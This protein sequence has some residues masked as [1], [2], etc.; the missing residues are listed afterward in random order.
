MV[1]T[2]E[3]R[4]SLIAFLITLAIALVAIFALP[5]QKGPEDFDEEY[6]KL[7]SEGE[8]EERMEA[9]PVNMY[10]DV[11]LSKIAQGYYSRPR[12]TTVGTVLKV[13]KQTDG[14]YH[15]ILTDGKY[16]IVCEIIP[17]MVPVLA[18]PADIKRPKKGMQIKIGGIVRKDDQHGWWELHPVVSWEQLHE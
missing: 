1:W 5:R 9:G 4:G 16:K 11:A 13:T 8:Q 6:A 17:D 7:E 18:D 14:D 3:R 15:I 2:W 12:A 10:P